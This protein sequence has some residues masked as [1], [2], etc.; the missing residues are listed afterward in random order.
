VNSNKNDL[1]MAT[2]MASV[3]PIPT[4]GYEPMPMARASSVITLFIKL[5][6]PVCPKHFKLRSAVRSAPVIYPL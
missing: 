5:C 6:L 3:E 2:T 4:E 1:D